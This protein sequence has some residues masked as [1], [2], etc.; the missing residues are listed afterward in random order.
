MAAEDG[1]SPSHG[2]ESSSTAAQ[3]A[4]PQQ[5]ESV[6]NITELEDFRTISALPDIAEIKAYH[7][8]RIQA[9][10]NSQQDPLSKLL[11]SHFF[12][13][14]NRLILAIRFEAPK[15]LIF[16]PLSEV[17][18]EH[19]NEVDDENHN[20]KEDTAHD[21][22]SDSEEPDSEDEADDPDNCLCL[23]ASK[24]QQDDVK[25]EWGG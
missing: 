13:L 21:E 4:S 8:T 14:R 25:R 11:E 2:A 7:T 19:G 5:L 12:R 17:E 16:A 15:E 24:N 3:Y 1:A 9:T 23:V 10:N 18:S 6:E 20:G 22:Q